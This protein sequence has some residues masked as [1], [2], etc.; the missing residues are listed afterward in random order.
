[1]CLLSLFWC[2]V[3]NVH[4]GGCLHPSVG[5]SLERLSSKNL[6]SL[7]AI[8]L[9]QSAEP[10]VTLYRA[11]ALVAWTGERKE[12]DV[13]LALMV[14]LGVVVRLILFQDVPQRGFPEQDKP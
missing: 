3:N 1:M 14:S 6:C 8:V 5:K 13:P 4:A 11:F 7:T 9:E 2:T 12:E 10:F